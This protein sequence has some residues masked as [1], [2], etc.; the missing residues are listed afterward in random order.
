MYIHM[1]VHWAGVNNAMMDG[2]TLDL[3]K[4]KLLIHKKK[5]KYNILLF[6]LINVSQQLRIMK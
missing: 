4:G 5:Y 6:Q 1:Y 3:V 2:S